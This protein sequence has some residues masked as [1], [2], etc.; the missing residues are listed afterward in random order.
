VRHLGLP[1]RR[2]PR[3]IVANRDFV[4]ASVDVHHAIEIGARVGIGF[5]GSRISIFDTAGVALPRG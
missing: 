4:A 5:R 1:P 3:G 2:P